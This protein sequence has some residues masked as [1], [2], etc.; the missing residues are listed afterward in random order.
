MHDINKSGLWYLLTFTIVGIIPL[1][2]LY[3]LKGDEMENN[4]KY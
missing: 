3:S 2:Y 1:I 4:Y